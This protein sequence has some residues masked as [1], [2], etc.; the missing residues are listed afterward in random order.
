[1]L[2]KEEAADVFDGS[3]ILLACIFIVK[4]KL[5]VSDAEVVGVGDD[6][7]AFEHLLLICAIKGQTLN[8]IIKQCFSYR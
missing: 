6:K 8:T 5:L 3:L 2:V 4:H 1:L 7:G